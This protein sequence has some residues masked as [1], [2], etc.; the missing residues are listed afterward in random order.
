MSTARTRT[1]PS[2]TPPSVVTGAPS[3]DGLAREAL[4][5]ATVDPLRAD[6]LAAEAEAAALVLGDWAAASV[7]RRARG[8]A[9]L[10][11]RH[12]DVAIIQLRAAIAAAAQVDASVLLAEA[13]MSLASALVLR[14]SGAE[15]A[16]AIDDAL[17]QLTGL[18]AARALVQRSAIAQDLGRSDEALQDLR[19]ALPTLRRYSDAE[20]EARALSNRSLLMTSRRLFAAAESDLLRAQSLCEAEGLR[21]QGAYVV[22]NLG[23]VAA[24]RGDI[25]GAL[26]HFDRA[27]QAYGALG[28]EVGALWVDRAKVLLSV[29]MMTEAR[30]AAETAARTLASLGRE[31]HLPEAQLILSTVALVQ[32][33]LQAAASTAQEA[34]R[35][36]AR[37]GRSEWLA[38]ARYAVLQ[39]QVSAAEQGTATRAGLTRRLGTVATE[40]DQAG[41][42]VPALGARVLAGRIA[43]AEGRHRA[44]RTQL[45]RVARARRFGPA[46]ARS[47]AWY[48]E[49]LLRE[50]EG[51][52]RGA[53]A[54]LRA[55]LRVVEDYRATLGATELRA[56]V[57]VHRGVIAQMGLRMALQDRNA[58]GV[59]W[60]GERSRSTAL[61]TRPVRPPKD[62]VLA[63]QL[64]DLRA[65][66][67]ELETART[68]GAASS[69]LVSRQI[70]IEQAIRD[71]SR[72][73]AASGEAHET[74]H[75]SLIALAQKLSETALVAYLEL[76]AHLHAVTVVEGRVRLHDLGLGDAVRHWVSYLPFALHRLASPATRPRQLAAAQSVQHRAAVELQEMLLMPLRHELGDRPLV[77]VPAGWLQSVPWSLLPACAG[78]A[79]S[80]APSAALWYAASGRQPQPHGAVV[81][82]AGPGLA[83]AATEASA[84][85]ALHPGSVLLTGAEATAESVARALSGARIAHVAAH[86][87]VRAD[88][89][90]FSSLLLADGPYTVYDLEALTQTPHHVVLAACDTALAHVTAGEEI[91]GLSATLLAQETAT[92]VAPVVAISDAETV[93]L[94]TTYH[95]LLRAGRSPAAALAEAQQHH[96]GDGVVAAACAASFVCLG[97]GGSPVW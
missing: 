1:L 42:T 33:D 86:G 87:H 23:C 66:M 11:Q 70:R 18:A 22:H 40:L 31:V 34:A 14:G 97:A 50:A 72:H 94:M 64:Q 96:A 20:W 49:A 60:W 55:G 52:R 83:G 68:S 15:G 88:N 69:T 57:T 59:L 36:F 82:I 32:N 9:A 4:H 48:A 19:A 92:L 71:H 10:Q 26:E 29:R 3:P 46:D 81:A 27:E 62:S 58:A 95:R 17:K 61:L 85:A 74:A 12:I 80:V 7:A 41:W 43:L 28:I 5:L 21:V 25:P 93:A 63:G 8:V 51:N 13:Q 73:L 47:R 84:I 90:L 76:D 75:P 37:Q 79:V 2:R 77:V 67:S 35:A 39:A 16:A 78:R 44:A 45:A 54:A 6:R 24:D 30:A 91:L 38:L 56:H 53:K 65:S 89:P